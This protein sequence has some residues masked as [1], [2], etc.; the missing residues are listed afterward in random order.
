MRNWADIGP[1]VNYGR[2]S[3]SRQQAWQQRVH[4]WLAESV[5]HRSIAM[6]RHAQVLLADAHAPD[7][8]ATGQSARDLP[9]LVA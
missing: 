6:H 9:P 2:L 5:Q 7:Y 4:P 8:F 1:N 3:I